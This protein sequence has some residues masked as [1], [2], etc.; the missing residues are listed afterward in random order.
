MAPGSAPATGSGRWLE[1][2]SGFAVVVTAVVVALMAVG[3]TNWRGGPVGYAFAGP[4][5][6]PTSAA[7]ALGTLA[8]YVV[9]L[10]VFALTVRAALRAPARQGPLGR[11]ARGAGRRCWVSAWSER[12]LRH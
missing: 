10:G 12:S 3:S 11:L 8:G 1:S 2:G 4:L 9:F 7:S 6:A 5:L